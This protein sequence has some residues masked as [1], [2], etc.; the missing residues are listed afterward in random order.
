[1]K[2]YSKSLG[3]K[4]GHC[5]YSEKVEGQDKPKWDFASDEKPEKKIARDMMR[6]EDAINSRYIAKIGDGKLDKITCVTCHRGK[7]EPM[8]SVDSLVGKP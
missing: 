4:C 3:V 6:M 7:T 8:I 1:M 2:G 5:H